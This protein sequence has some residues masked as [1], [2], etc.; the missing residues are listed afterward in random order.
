MRLIIVVL[1]L[2]L[3]VCLTSC[4][5]EN[6]IE[7]DEDEILEEIPDRERRDAIPQPIRGTC[8]IHLVIYL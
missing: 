2:Y 4:S 7:V 3:M 5:I 6:K 1:A 8:F